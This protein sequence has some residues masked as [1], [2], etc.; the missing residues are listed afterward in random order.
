M[1]LLPSLVH[2]CLLSCY[3]LK[4]LEWDKGQTLVLEK[5]QEN[6]IE[7]PLQSSL[8]YILVQMVHASYYAPYS[9]WPYIKHEANM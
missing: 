2:Y 6:L 4:F 3:N 8:S 7:S 1:K 5:I 9:K